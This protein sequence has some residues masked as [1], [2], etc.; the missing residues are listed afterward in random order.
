MST[1]Q[2]PRASPSQT[3]IIMSAAAFACSGFIGP[4]RR[5]R[6]A[7]S[8]LPCELPILDAMRPICLGAEA[9]LPV[10]LVVL[11]I[12]FEPHHPAVALERQHMGGNPIEKPPVVADDDGA[13]GVVD[14]RLLERAQRVDVEVVGRLV[15]QQQ[16]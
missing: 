8:A 14:Q 3:V 13:A 9:T 1:W 10:G 5:I 16:V 11:V 7:E 2:V 6:S 4:P 12:A 15:Q